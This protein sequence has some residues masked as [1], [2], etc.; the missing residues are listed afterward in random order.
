MLIQQPRAQVFFV[1]ARRYRRLLVAAAITLATSLGLLGLIATAKWHGREALHNDT[2]TIIARAGDQLVRALRSRRGTLTLLRDALQQS[3]DLNA[4]QLKAFGASA[5]GHTRHLLGVGLILREQPPTWWSW[6][7][8]LNRNERES[9]NGAIAA[10][11]RRSSAWRAP[12]TFSAAAKNHRQIL[13]MTEPLRGGQEPP[14]AILGAFDLKPLLQDFFTLGILQGYPAQLLDGNQVLYRSAQ[15]AADGADQS[16][17]VVERAIAIDSL[18]WTLQMQPGAN[19]VNQTLSWLTFAVVALSILAGTGVIFVV[20]IMAAR[21]WILQ[22]AVTRRTAALR[23]SL[24]RVRQLA[25]KDEL[26]GLYNRR[27]FLRR[28]TWECDRAKRYQR[29]LACL[30]VDVNGFKQVN[31][32][33]GHLTGDCVLKQVAQELQ[34]LLR[35]SDIIARFGGD[36]FVVALPET[37]PEQA[38]SVVEKLRQLR[39]PVPKEAAKDLPPVS[40]SVGASQPLDSKDTPEGLLEAADQA[41]YA[42][43]LQHKRSL[44][45][46]A[47]P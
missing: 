29:P 11:L 43:K 26:T 34:T 38:E 20:W 16:P 28:W 40:L 27:F 5:V 10:Q 35:Q 8:S 44:V 36:E 25:T 4:A 15:W 47:M 24:Q 2:Q 9:L 31:D 22:R 19:R 23:R 42:H 18:R 41:L 3:S 30:M 17:V 13:M 6:P 46:S 32:R 21:T 39:I 7:A 33:L 45:S 37:T 14:R 1:T 12:E